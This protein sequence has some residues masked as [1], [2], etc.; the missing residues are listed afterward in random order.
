LDHTLHA[1][2]QARLRAQLPAKAALD[3][4]QKLEAYLNQLRTPG[5]RPTQKR[6]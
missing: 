1:A 2:E 5:A 6:N 3:M 4:V